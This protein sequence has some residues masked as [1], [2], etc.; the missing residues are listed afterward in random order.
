M[1]DEPAHPP[2]SPGEALQHAFALH[3]PACRLYAHQ[4]VG[5][6]LADDAVQEAFIRL[7]REL[8]R[9]GNAL[10][11]PRAWLLTA[12]RSASL[13]LLRSQKRRI[14]RESIA[15]RPEPFVPDPLS[16]IQAGELAVALSSL[17]PRQ[18][19]IVALRTWG[20]MGFAE[21]AELLGIAISTAHADYTTALRRLRETLD[22]KIS[23][24][25]A[26]SHGR[27]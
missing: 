25:A 3:A 19:E 22:P 7:F 16:P 26:S 8:V 27:P 5:P 14:R 10:R 2:A 17:P 23:A 1:T 6:D 11:A 12:T 18:R 13:D 9:S 4:I 24:S 20:E 21:I 15:R